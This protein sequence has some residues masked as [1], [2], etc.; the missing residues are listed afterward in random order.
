VDVSQLASQQVIASSV[1]Q[2]TVTSTVTTTTTNSMGTPGSVTGVGS[3]SGGKLSTGSYYYRV[4]ALDSSGHESAASAEKSVSVSSSNSKG[5]VALSWGAVTNAASYRV[6]FGTQSG[7]ETSYFTSSG[8]SATDDGKG[9]TKSGSPLNSAVTWTTSSTSTVT[10]LQDVKPTEELGYSGTFTVNGWGVNVSATDSLVSIA[11]KVNTGTTSPTG[12]TATAVQTGNNGESENSNNNRTSG[13]LVNGTY[14]YRVSAVDAYGNESAASDVAS[15]VIRSNKNSVSLSWTGLGNVSSY[16]V[17]YGTSSGS[18]NS[19]YASSGTGT[20]FTDLGDSTK[21]HADSPMFF[22]SA[23]NAF[24]FGSSQYTGVTASISKGALLFTGS[25]GNSIALEDTSGTVLQSIGMLYKNTGNGTVAI[26]TMN[27]QYQSAKSAVY[28][29]NGVENT[30]KSNDATVDGVSLTLSNVGSA[31][32]TVTQDDTQAVQT[33]SDF[34]NSYN[35]VMDTL[36]RTVLGGGALAENTMMQQIYSDLVRYLTPPP[37]DSLG[38]TSVSDIGVKA[39]EQKRTSISQLVLEQLASKDNMPSAGDTTSSK[40]SDSFP[41]GEGQYSLLNQ[42]RKVGVNSPDNHKIS[43]NPTALKSA[44][45]NNHNGV[46]GVLNYMA[47]QMQNRLDVHLQPSVGTLAMQKQI[48]GYYSS[49]QQ[50]VTS[51]MGNVVNITENRFKAQNVNTILQSV[52]A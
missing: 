32:V 17:Y 42:S 38:G 13:N 33:V 19:Y 44:L 5:S 47:G 23:N 29:I 18:M 50:Q 28:K 8:T 46:G 3:S 20:S 31:R 26:N 41:A 36:N 40:P 25:N 22:T 4:S 16:R 2:K 15:A 7:K 14:Y 52:R 30:S 9:S 34:A 45:K 49:N 6:Y 37:P 10:S 51:L 11:Q 21:A 12:L 27:D 1:P 48:I 39:V 35:N 43:I 24:G